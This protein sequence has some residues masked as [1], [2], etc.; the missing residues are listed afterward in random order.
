[1]NQPADRLLFSLVYLKTNPLQTMHGLQFG[2]SQSQ[3]NYWMH[4]LLP[5]AQAALQELNMT[6]E[7]DGSKVADN[8]LAHEGTPD[9]ALD[10]TERRRQRPQDATEQKEPYSGKKKTHTDK[11]IIWVCFI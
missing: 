7:R 5:V 2:L 6:P 4:H 10:G 11:N 9:F 1:L 3:T 8:A